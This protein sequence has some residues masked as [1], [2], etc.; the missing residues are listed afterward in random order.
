PA[1]AHQHHEF[2]IAH[3]EVHAVDR[4]EP[5]G[6]GLLDLRERERGHQP[7]MPPEAAPSMKCRCAAKKTAT[8]GMSATTEI[9]MTFAHSTS[10]VAPMLILSASDTGYFSTEA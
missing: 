5:V 1:R 2:P 8:D 7:L 10:S 4:F 3:L 6:V 9:A